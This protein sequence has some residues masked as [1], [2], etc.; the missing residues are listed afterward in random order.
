[1]AKLTRMGLLPQTK[2][3]N[4]NHFLCF[5]LAFVAL[6]VLIFGDYIYVLGGD[7]TNGNNLASMESLLVGG[8]SWT[9]NSPM[10]TPI[11]CREVVKV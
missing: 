6:P 8:N 5:A 7:D 9:S 10:G 1:M 3:L 11:V 4:A 2:L